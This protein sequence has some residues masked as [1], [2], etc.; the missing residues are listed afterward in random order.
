M[1]HI[2]GNLP[3]RAVDLPINAKSV[4]LG[5]VSEFSHRRCLKHDVSK[6]KYGGST[7]TFREKEK[8]RPEEWSC[9]KQILSLGAGDLHLSARARMDPVFI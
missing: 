3:P 6:P 9:P 5:Q 4:A 1:K 2:N 8:S 7:L